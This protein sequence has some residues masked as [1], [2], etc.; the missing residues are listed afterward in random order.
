MV[1]NACNATATDDVVATVGIVA[2]DDVVVV[3]GAMA[4]VAVWV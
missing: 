3:V 1:V 4:A 2:A